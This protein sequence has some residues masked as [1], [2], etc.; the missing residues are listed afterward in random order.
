MS[1]PPLQAL[2]CDLDG[3]LVDTLADVAGA[4]NRVLAAR[5]LP[6]HPD[7]A[8]RAM[9]GKGMRN[10]VTLALPPAARGP[11]DLEAALAAMM[12]EY[13]A[14]P[15]VHSRPYDGVP[16]LLAEMA[17]RGVPVAVLSNKPDPL[18]QATVQGLF[19]ADA[20]RGVFGER[21]G[22]PRKPDPAAALAL[23]RDLG[24]APG[25]VL[26]LGDSTVDLETARNAGMVA[27]AALWGFTDAADLAAAGADALLAHPLEA[28][29]LLRA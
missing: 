5:G 13:G 8:Y 6:V 21:P 2:I 24:V 27:G 17:R 14:H 29:A 18:T 10:L 28:A 23:C 22:V 1:R 19:P 16:G 12:A 3:T 25:E 7:R 4:M 11:A 15:V 9:L 26:F 20:F